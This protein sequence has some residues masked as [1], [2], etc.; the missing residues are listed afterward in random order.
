MASRSSVLPEKLKHDGWLSGLETAGEIENIERN[1]YHIFLCLG[2]LQEA[3]QSKKEC[4][5]IKLMAEQEVVLLRQQLL[6]LRQ[7]L[8][9]AQADNMRMSKQQENQVSED[10]L[11]SSLLTGSGDRKRHHAACSSHQRPQWESEQ[12]ALLAPTSACLLPPSQPRNHG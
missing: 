3:M 4:L 7:A 10:P 8:A 11:P 9:R 12:T 2:C 5:N 6:A 1:V